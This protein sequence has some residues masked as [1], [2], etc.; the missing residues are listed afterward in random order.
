MVSVNILKNC[1]FYYCTIRF[2]KMYSIVKSH[3]V[4]VVVCLTI[5][6]Q[7]DGVNKVRVAI[8]YYLNANNTFFHLI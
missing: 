4:F 6:S 2:K 1:I 7:A 8:K 5:T 3:I